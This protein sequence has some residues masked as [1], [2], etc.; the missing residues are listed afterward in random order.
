MEKNNEI[1]YP[2]LLY[3]GIT[4]EKNA[5]VEANVYVEKFESD[6][7]RLIETGH[8]FVSLRDIGDALKG[9]TSIPENSICIALHGGYMNH[10]QYAFPI[11]KKY[12]IHADY[13][14][15]P[16]LAGATN[17][18]G[19]VNFCPHFGWK[20]AQIMQQSGLVDIN[21]MWH[22]FDEGRNYKEAIHSKVSMI[23]NNVGNCVR[24]NTFAIDINRNYIEKDKALK[25]EGIE[26]NIVNYLSFKT[27]NMK[28]GHIPYIAVNQEAN[29]LDVLESFVFTCNRLAAL[30]KEKDNEK[31]EKFD[32]GWQSGKKSVILPIDKEPKIKNLLRNAIPLSVIGAKRR[33]KADLI[34][35]NNFIE[36]VFRPWYHYFD[37]DNHMYLN[38]P[39]LKCCRMEKDILDQS[40]I[41]IADLIISGLESGYYEDV[42]ADQYYIPGKGGYKWRHLA[43][44]LLIYGYDSDKDVFSVLTYTSNEHYEDL[45]IETNDLIRA[46]KS[47]YFMSIQFI[48]NN[49]ECQVE[50]NICLLLD[51]LKRYISSGY[52]YS[53]NSKNSHYDYHQLCNYNACKSFSG[54]I[55]NTAV[56][57]NWIYSVCL[58]GYLEHKKIMGWRIDYISKREYL[59][60]PLYLEY[61]EYSSKVTT[62]ILNISIKYGLT[63]DLKLIDRICDMIDELNAREYEALQCLITE[64]SDR[65]KVEK[66]KAQ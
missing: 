27:D 55:K 38:W 46:C 56:K 5:A 40:N 37:Y 57:E 66:S 8:Y 36:V 45:L 11:L 63:H 48:K 33:D 58:F 62:L 10:Y 32:Y 16:E 31:H 26:N 44:N 21:P 19:I 60:N 42:W 35:L 22:P 6:I 52:E 61:K 65:V 29:V 4:G 24:Q 41:C 53:D 9:K 13:F 7:V 23:T 2:I 3:T 18:P 28:K 34:V 43:H 15:S 49:T 51:K 39:E 50:Y 30:D 17:Y 54:Y 25:D 64:L 1:Y 59:S 47:E 12:A 20:E 14:V